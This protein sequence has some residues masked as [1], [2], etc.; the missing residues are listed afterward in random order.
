MSV[1]GDNPARRDG[2]APASMA[3][4]RPHQVA[5]VS[6]RSFYILSS[7]KMT[8][9]GVRRDRMPRSMDHV[10]ASQRGK[11][12]SKHA[13]LPKGARMPIR[14]HDFVSVGLIVGKA[15]VGNRHALAA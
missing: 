6:S 15:Q 1:A 10:L 13:V 8:T 3:S 14:G 2:T 11:Q 7:V 12:T 4:V 9:L 5:V